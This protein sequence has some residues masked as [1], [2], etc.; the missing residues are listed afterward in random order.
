L[1][2]TTAHALTDSFGV[3]SVEEIAVHN[4]S[5]DRHYVKDIPFP[6]SGSLVVVRR[7]NEIFI[8]HGDTH[9]LLGDL[10]TVIGNAAALEEFRRLLQ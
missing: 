1:R 9:L 3:Y 6:R 2:P 7:D 10:V 8:P 4:T 5:I